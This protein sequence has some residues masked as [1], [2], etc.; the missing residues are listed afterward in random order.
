MRARSKHLKDM[1][2]QRIHRAKKEELHIAFATAFEDRESREIVSRTDCVYLPIER[3]EVLWD[4]KG[5]G[6]QQRIR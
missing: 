1:E 4:S 2:R 5:E 6:S 3:G